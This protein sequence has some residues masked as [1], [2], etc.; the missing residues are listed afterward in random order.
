MNRLLMPRST[1]LWLIKNTKLSLKQ[2]SDFCSIS[3]LD[4][5]VIKGE[6]AEKSLTANDPIARGQ[7][8]SSEIDR[9]EKDPESSLKLNIKVDLNISAVR[10]IPHALRKYLP[11]CIVWMK[12]NHSQLTN[13][14][15][16]K[17]FGIKV[18][19]VNDVI[20]ND[21]VYI[22]SNDPILVGICS[23]DYLDRFIKERK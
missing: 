18:K 11:N 17:F 22:S 4:L 6:F 7:L 16:A 2:I 20:D 19:D 14:E 10:K 5:H 1:A 9:C 13:K 23:K 12:K 3:V 8:L 15:I 21:E